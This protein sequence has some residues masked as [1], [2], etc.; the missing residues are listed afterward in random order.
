MDTK[1]KQTAANGRRQAAMLGR[2]WQPRRLASLTGAAATLSL[3]LAGIAVTT[4]EAGP[5][6]PVSATPGTW[7]RLGL[8]QNAPAAVWRAPDDRDWVVWSSHGGV[9]SLAIISPHGG[10]AVKPKTIISGW[11]SVSFT[12]SLVARNHGPLLIFSGQ[13]PGPRLSQGCV[14][15]A[16]PASPRWAIQS[17]TLSQNCTFANVGYG[18]AAE[19]RSGQLSAAWAGGLG[20]E[21]R[22]GISPFPA[23]TADLQISVG[24]AHAT[25]VAEANN[26]FGNGH[27]YAAFYRF[28]SKNP[29]QDGVYV[30]DL[31]ANGPVLKAPGSGTNTVTNGPLITA[32]A[33]TTNGR[34]YIAYCSNTATCKTNLLW[35][36]GATKTI[37]IPLSGTAKHLAM[38][39]G[40]GGRLWL[41]WYNVQT[42]RVYTVRTNKADNRFGP[43]RSYPAP[44]FADG[45]THVALTGGSYGRVDVAVECFAPITTKQTL[46]LTQS[47]AALTIGANPS[48]IRNTNAVKVTFTVRDAGDPVA[49][50][51]VRIH[52]KTLLTGKNGTVTITFAKNT[53]T[54]KYLATA[55]LANYFSATT[56][57]TVKS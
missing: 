40:P 9:Y 11:S 35:K 12:P 16:L 54:G 44:C 39:Q 37:T 23:G 14:V 45:N 25:A 13:G 22:L 43:V 34:V 21:Y 28:F 52:G 2:R 53:K 1:V 32:M 17:W 20:V 3:L 4:A 8:S 56:T 24:L 48:T 42:N 38:S 36:L 27:T 51:T 47:L 50:A 15:G 19:S 31:T 46:Y 29:S 18:D 41:A 57:V 7:I 33:A 30:K 55:S 5:R 6:T 49:G 26:S 10:F